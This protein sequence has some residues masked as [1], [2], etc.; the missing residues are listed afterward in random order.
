MST[1]QLAAQRSLITGEP[2]RFAW[3][4]PRFRS[5]LSG[6]LLWLICAF[7][8]LIAGQYAHLYW[9]CRHPAPVVDAHK[10]EA[11]E[12]ELSDMHYVYVTKAFPQPESAR[13]TP[14]TQAA[15]PDE[16]PETAVDNNGGENDWTHSPDGTLATRQLPGNS[17]EASPS[18]KERLMQALKEQQQEYVPS[19]VEPA[20]PATQSDNVQ[21]SM[22]IPQLGEQP[23]HLQQRLPAMQYQSHVYMPDSA[24][25]RV[26]L[27]GKTYKPGDQLGNGV[28]IK[29]LRP[30][31]LIVDIDGATY[32]LPALVNW[33][34]AIR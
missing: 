13:I 29:A 10:H 25:S 32:S 20:E 26:V 34:P 22:D 6:L 19:D 1:I 15:I 18:L 8:L 3:R 4:L 14:A 23:A 27:D 31:S 33:E 21:P 24:S 9:Q 17:E 11:P 16:F 5:L 2:I 28:T 30:R 7:A 12:A